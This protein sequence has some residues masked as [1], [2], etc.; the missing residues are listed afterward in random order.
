MTFFLVGTIQLVRRYEYELDRVQIHDRTRLEFFFKI[1][2]TPQFGL[3]YSTA[4]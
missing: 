1:K 4:I 3:G 2:A